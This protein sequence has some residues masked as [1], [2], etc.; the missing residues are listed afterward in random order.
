MIRF[1]G[2]LPPVAGV[3]FVNRLGAE[4]DE[5]GAPPGAEKRDEPRA[6]RWRPTRSARD[7]GDG[8]ATKRVTRSADVVFVVDPR[9][10][11]A[12]M[13]IRASRAT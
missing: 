5:R 12:G 8:G 6:A 7:R 11:G 2:A 9:R 3:R 4:T 10:T 13:R 1:R